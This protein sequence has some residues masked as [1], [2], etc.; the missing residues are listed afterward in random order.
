MICGV[1][2]PLQSNMAY[3]HSCQGL[4]PTTAGLE[5][6]RSY[7]YGC[8]AAVKRHVKPKVFSR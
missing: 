2:Y 4:E 5:G 7:H 6:Y 8:P 1:N 3:V